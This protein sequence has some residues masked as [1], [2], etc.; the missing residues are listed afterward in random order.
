M[1]LRKLYP[2]RTVMCFASSSEFLIQCHY[3]N[4]RVKSDPLLIWQRVDGWGVIVWVNLVKLF[5][6]HVFCVAYLI[7]EALIIKGKN[8]LHVKQSYFL[9]L[10]SEIN[11]YIGTQ[12]DE[13][14]VIWI[15]L[16]GSW[17]EGKREM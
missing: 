17:T 7:Y 16:W 10:D 6:V 1:R 8:D 2:V 14:D 12:K 3:L 5:G 9:S 4:F 13:S 11:C 15:W